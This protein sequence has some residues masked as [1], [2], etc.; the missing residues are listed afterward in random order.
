MGRVVR[1]VVDHDLLRGGD[2]AVQVEL[3]RFVLGERG[4]GVVEMHGGGLASGVVDDGIV[5]LED[6]LGMREK[7]GANAVVVDRPEDD[8]APAGLGGLGVRR[9]LR[10]VLEMTHCSSRSSRSRRR[11]SSRSR[12]GRR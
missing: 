6:T 2:H 1:N 12:M 3:E 9:K 7:E 8:V 10:W 11:S 4:L 5:G